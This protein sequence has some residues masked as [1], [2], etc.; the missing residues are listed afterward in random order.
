MHC[1][2]PPDSH[3]PAACAPKREREGGHVAGEASIAGDGDSELLRVDHLWPGHH[4]HTD[5]T[6]SNPGLFMNEEV[7]RGDIGWVEAC[8]ACRERA[9]KQRGLPVQRARPWRL[10]NHPS[11]PQSV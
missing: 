7:P 8:K 6:S 2:G 1:A 5:A 9:E 4:D 3:C 11:S 10:R